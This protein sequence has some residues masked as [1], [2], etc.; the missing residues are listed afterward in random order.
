MCIFCG[1]QCG[2]VGEFL[3]SLGLPFLALYFSRIKNALLRLK[4]R[5]DHPG[6]EIQAEPVKCGC[7][8]QPRQDCGAIQA[9]SINPGDLGLLELKSQENGAAEFSLN[10]SRLSNQINKKIVSGVKGW[11]LLLCL[12]F[13]IFIPATYL[14]Q[15]NCVLDLF[16]STRNRILLFMFKATIWPITS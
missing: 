16:N 6:Q 12:N 9:R 1:G 5:I 3:I 8:G 11:L 10:T 2:G 15:V 13:T 7:C 14:Y 4:N